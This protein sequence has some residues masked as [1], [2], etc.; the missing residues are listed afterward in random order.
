[1]DIVSA[2]V[3]GHLGENRRYQGLSFDCPPWYCFKS[4]FMLVV[5]W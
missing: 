1:M 4:V 2:E 5:Y 3:L